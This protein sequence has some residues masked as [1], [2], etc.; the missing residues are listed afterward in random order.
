MASNLRIFDH[1]AKSLAYLE[2]PTTPRSWVL[3]GYG[4]AEFSLGLQYLQDRFNPREETIVKYNNLVFITHV[5]TQD[6][7]GNVNGKLPDWVGIILPDRNWTFRVLGVTA[8]SAEA[9]LTFRPMP[10]TAIKG[11]PG[12]MFKEMLN[13]AHAVADDIVIQPGIIEDIPEQFA[14]SL[15]TSAY[16]HIKKLCMNAGMNFDVTGQ[17]D[18]RGNLQL[19]ANLY[20][21]K[22]ADTRLELTQDNTE[23]GG[24]LLTEQGTPYNVVYGYTQASTKESRYFAKGVNQAS[25]D[26]YGVLAKNQTFSG[27]RD[28]TALANAAQ[29]MADALAEPVK[30][31]RRVALD[32]G[33]TFDSLA[34]GNTVG[35]KDTTVGFKPGGGFGFEARARIL[36]LD[37]NDLTVGKAPLHL[38]II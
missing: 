9:I 8:Y 2:A 32:S 17:I 28:Q 18:S 33:D 10:L 22:G 4:K 16:D 11:T 30:M 29:T 7:A 15:V 6:A 26:K 14:D 12:S 38:E 20:R 35:V 36:S 27:I 21:R 5:P 25:V 31:I 13:Y 37:Y 3:N 24:P 19:Y 23:G 34:V 1:F